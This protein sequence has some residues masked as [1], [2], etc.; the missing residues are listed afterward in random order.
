MKIAHQTPFQHPRPA[1]RNEDGLITMIFVILLAVMMILVMA[2]GSSLWRLHR[3]VKFL[4]Q[5][6]IQRLNHPP[7]GATAPTTS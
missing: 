6:Q 3:D 5:Q 1:K 7:T 2:E 4:E